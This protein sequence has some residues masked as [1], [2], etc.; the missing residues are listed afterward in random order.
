MSNRSL[1][2]FSEYKFKGNCLIVNYINYTIKQLP[3]LPSATS[4]NNNIKRNFGFCSKT[5]LLNVIWDF[6]TSEV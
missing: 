6:A 4:L 3:K 1:G 5:T 2:N